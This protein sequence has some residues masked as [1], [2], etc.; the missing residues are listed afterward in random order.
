VTDFGLA[1]W[2]DTLS[3]DHVQ[4]IRRGTIP[5]MSPEQFAGDPDSFGPLSDLYS[6]G[7][8][9]YE[10]LGGR[11]PFF[12]DNDEKLVRKIMRAEPDWL[13]DQSPVPKDLAHI[14]HKCLEKKPSD[15][16]RSALELAC[17]VEAWLSTEQAFQG[18][19]TSIE[20]AI[21][22]A[23]NN[24]RDELIEIEKTFKSVH[25]SFP[26]EPV[27]YFKQGHSERILAP[28]F[29]P[30]TDIAKITSRIVEEGNT[31]PAALRVFWSSLTDEHQW[32]W[33]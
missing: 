13:P 3:R 17:A 5:Y 21:S 26:N 4:E 1:L 24:A 11:R 31:V 12:G 6:L 7:V 18:A 15:R 19:P 33:R 23:F 16:Y 8:I 30:N 10:L 27:A 32:C 20:R 22:K 25:V 28:L 9:M 2:R 14:C 29:E